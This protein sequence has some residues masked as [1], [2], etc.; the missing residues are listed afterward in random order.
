MET[1]HQ[2]PMS[3][4]GIPSNTV[5]GLYS[6]QA[7]TQSQCQMIFHQSILFCFDNLL[8]YP[9]SNRVQNLHQAII[10]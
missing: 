4:S 9:S 5:T 8:A 10:K 1:A 3:Q 7:T 6:K 2:I